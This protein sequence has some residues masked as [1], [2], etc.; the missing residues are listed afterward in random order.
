MIFSDAAATVGRTPMVELGRLARGLPDKIVAKLEM[1]NPCGSV[2][3]R[4]GAAMIE[5]AE[6]RG[7]VRPGMTNRSFRARR[8]VARAFTRR[9]AAS[10]RSLSIP[11]TKPRHRLVVQAQV[12]DRLNVPDVPESGFN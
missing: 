2:K 11:L 12:Q 10:K 1:R 3:D 6:H 8:A 4:V 9:R 5:N 7:I